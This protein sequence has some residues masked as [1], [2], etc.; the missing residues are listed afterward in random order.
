MPNVSL[1]NALTQLLTV[2]PTLKCQIFLYGPL[3]S[4]TDNDTVT[5]NNHLL[6]LLMQIVEIKLTPQKLKINQPMKGLGYSFS[7][8]AQKLENGRFTRF[9]V[10]AVSTDDTI[11]NSAVILL[12]SRPTI[13][14][15]PSSQRTSDNNIANDEGNMQI[16]SNINAIMHVNF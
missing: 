13:E 9:A 7:N 11:D 3:Q 6:E 5:K 12:E 14:I 15:I 16:N 4:T 10:G 1:E 2:C 8:D